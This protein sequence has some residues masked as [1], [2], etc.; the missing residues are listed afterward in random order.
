L[1][2][3]VLLGGRDMRARMNSDDIDRGPKRQLE[4]KCGHARARRKPAYELRPGIGKEL[5]LTRPR[6]RQLR[7]MC[8]PALA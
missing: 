3:T 8:Q 6:G 7:R 5:H 1:E 2:R 4:H